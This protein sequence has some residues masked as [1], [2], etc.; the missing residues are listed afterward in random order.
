MTHLNWIG[1][2]C[3]RGGSAPA[4]HAVANGSGAA[5]G[6]GELHA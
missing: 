3:A 6:L 2:G 1:I 5:L 4:R